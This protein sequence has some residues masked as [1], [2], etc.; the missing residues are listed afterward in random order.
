MKMRGRVVDA[1]EDLTQLSYIGQ[2][3]ERIPIRLGQD[4]SCLVRHLDLSF[5]QLRSLDGAERFRN[6]EELI[7]DNNALDDNITLPFLPKLHTLMLNKNKIS[8]YLERLLDILSKQL[9]SLK[10]LSLLGNPACPDQLSSADSSDE[11]YEQYRIF[12]LYN[13]PKLKFLDSTPVKMTERTEAQRRGCFLRV[14]RPPSDLEEKRTKRDDDDNPYTPLPKDTNVE[15][16]H[17]G[18][19]FWKIAIYKCVNQLN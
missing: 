15:P 18:W 6:L 4:N 16:K 10:Y 8:L 1:I 17:E 9:P 19:L 14:A 2:D 3:C 12:V 5:N 13:L 11:D 7:L